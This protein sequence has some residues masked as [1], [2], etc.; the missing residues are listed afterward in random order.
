MYNMYNGYQLAPIKLITSAKILRAPCTIQSLQLLN[1]I[2]PILVEHTTISFFL[3]TQEFLFSESYFLKGKRTFGCECIV[4]I[5]N[6][7]L[8]TNYVGK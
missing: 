1:N 2:L 8:S 6:H 4:K 3:S 5:F 7:T